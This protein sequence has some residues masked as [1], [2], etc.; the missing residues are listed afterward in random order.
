[1]IIFFL[2]W[3]MKREDGYVVFKGG[4]RSVLLEKSVNV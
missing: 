4:N 1:M 3:S 2:I